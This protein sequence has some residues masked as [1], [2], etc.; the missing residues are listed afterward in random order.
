ML[1]MTYRNFQQRLKFLIASTGRNPDAYSSHSL[2]RG[3]STF[4]AVAGVHRHVIQ[5]VGDWKSDAVDQYLHNHL[6]SKVQAA[7]MMRD[8]LHCSE[9]R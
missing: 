4:A 6:Q 3:G 7:Q 2:R 9:L 1:P 8:E 5:Q